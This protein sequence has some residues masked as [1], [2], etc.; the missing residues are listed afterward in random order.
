MKKSILLF[1]L[2]ATL[3][4]TPIAYADEQ[5]E[6]KRGCIKDY[7]LVK[8]ETDQ[9]LLG[10][11]QQVCAKENK[12]NQEVKQELQVQ[13]AK[14]FQELGKNMKTLQLVEQLEN[15]GV[16]HPDLTDAH[17]LAGV[18]IAKNAL[19]YM[20]TEQMRFLSDEVTYPAAKELSDTIRASVPAPD[21]SS[22]K[23]ITDASLAKKAAAQ[24]AAARK[25]S[26]NASR[27]KTTRTASTKAATATRTTAPAAKPVASNNPFESLRK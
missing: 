24:R 18:S 27:A 5:I 1:P 23:A 20:R 19:N 25:A 4:A 26:S 22:A 21:T 15:Q 3:C 7:P 16:R 9:A 10:I 11:Y 2:M 12:K 8:G 14:R 13:A 17:F 6:L